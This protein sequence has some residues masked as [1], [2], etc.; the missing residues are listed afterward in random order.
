[1]LAKGWIKPGVS[2]YGSPVL[3]VQKKDWRI[4]DMYRLIMH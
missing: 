4:V 1:M 2:P 3:F